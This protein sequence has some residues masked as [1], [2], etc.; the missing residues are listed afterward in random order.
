MVTAQFR[1]LRSRQQSVKLGPIVSSA[2]KEAEQISIVSNCA[3]VYI[4]SPEKEGGGPRGGGGG[5]L[6]EKTNTRHELS[7]GMRQRICYRRSPLLLGIAIGLSRMNL[8]QR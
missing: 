3:E 8:Q 2:K 5:A 1:C 6:G 4:P 7:G